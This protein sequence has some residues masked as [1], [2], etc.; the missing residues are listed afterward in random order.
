MGFLDLLCIV[1]AVT[2]DAVTGSIST[3]GLATD[4]SHRS[5]SFM[6]LE[7]SLTEN[8]NGLP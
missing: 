7:T 2:A 5:G 3:F 1:S 6:V 8:P 4:K